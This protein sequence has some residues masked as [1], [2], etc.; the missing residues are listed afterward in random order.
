MTPTQAPPQ[1]KRLEPENPTLTS[2]SASRVF[3]PCRLD[4]AS[5]GAIC[6]MRDITPLVAGLL[7]L[8]LDQSLGLDIHELVA[9]LMAPITFGPQPEPGTGPLVEAAGLAGVAPSQIVLC[10]LAAAAVSSNICASQEDPG[11]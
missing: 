4:L 6:D 9:T 2:A 8:K 10:C 7:Q 11:D 1:P 3:W 5:A